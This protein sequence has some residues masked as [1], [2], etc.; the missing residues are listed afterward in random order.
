MVI[1]LIF[2]VSCLIVGEAKRAVFRTTSKFPE[3][4]EAL[5]RYLE[6]YLVSQTSR[7][8]YFNML[9]FLVQ[10][11]TCKLHSVTTLDVPQGTI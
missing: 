11:K 1:G 10:N 4:V 7:V 2:H 5:W 6:N 8:E 9:I 3:L